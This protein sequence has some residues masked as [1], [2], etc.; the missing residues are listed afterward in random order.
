M[1]V[2]LSPW[3][4][5]GVRAARLFEEEYSH[6][7]QRKESPKREESISHASK[8]AGLTAVS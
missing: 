4:R 7:R 6:L 2:T 3:E 8:E 5:E 1:R